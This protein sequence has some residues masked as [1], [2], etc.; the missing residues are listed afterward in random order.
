MSELAERALHTRIGRSV[1]AI[2]QSFLDN[3][4]YITGRTLENATTLDLY[5]ALSYTIRD[6]ILARM[7]AADK[8]YKP[9]GAKT[10]AF[11]SAEFMLGPHLANNILNLKL[12]DN[13]RQAMCGLKVDLEAILEAEQEPGLGNGGLGR[14]AACYMDSLA[15]LEIPAVGYG[16]RYEYGIFDQ[17]VKDGWQVEVADAWLR[18]GN[19]WE[20]G[21]HGRYPVMFGGRVEHYQVDEH[22]QGVRWI[23]EST[24]YGVAYDT[25][26]LGY[27]VLNVNLLRLWKSEARESFHFQAFNAGDYYGAIGDMVTAQTISKVLYPNDEPEAGKALRLRQQYFFV[28]CSL[29]DMIRLTL[30]EKG[31]LEHFPERFVIQLNDTHPCE[32]SLGGTHKNRGY[33]SVTEWR[34]SRFDS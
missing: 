25:F 3:L 27:G 26:I 12:E 2:R 9:D 13:V 19:P 4:F 11:L 16:I 18:D 28:S 15:T 34:G 5:T 30:Q 29:Q 1:E 23:P 14:L 20:L 10:V 31:G 33:N 32:E 6:R 7:V 17:T 24:I 8:S 21:R 22:R